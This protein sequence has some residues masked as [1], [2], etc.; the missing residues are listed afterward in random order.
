MPDICRVI[1][2]CAL[3]L[4]SVVGQAS[5]VDAKNFITIASGSVPSP[6]DPRIR[7][8][9]RQLNLIDST[10]ASTS[11]GAGIHDKI[12]MAHSNLKVS[13]SLFELLNDFVSIASAQ[14]NRIDDSSLLALYVLER[15]SGQSH[16]QT[17]AR[18]KKNPG[19][20]IAKWS[21]R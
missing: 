15:N 21:S 13:Q 4:S 17:V 2:V 19:A 3:L 16:I 10:C 11:K 8:V 12:G 20:L 6:T 5:E 14:C 1:F 18:L 9:E 7:T